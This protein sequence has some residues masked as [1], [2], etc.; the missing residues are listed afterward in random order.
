VENKWFFF[1][2]LLLVV[3]VALGGGEVLHWRRV[4]LIGKLIRVNFFNRHVPLKLDDVIAL[5]Y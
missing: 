5:K 4:K 2:L 3:N 1:F